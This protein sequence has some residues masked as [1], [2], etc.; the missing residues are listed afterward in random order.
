[1]EQLRQILF[2]IAM[3]FALVYTIIVLVALLF[4]A[5]GIGKIKKTTFDWKSLGVVLL[6]IIGVYLWFK[7]FNII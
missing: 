4:A 1:M 3:G 2:L 7:Y 6:W 5:F